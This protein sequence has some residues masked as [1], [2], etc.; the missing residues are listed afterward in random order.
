MKPEILYSV[1]A[2][3]GPTLRC[4]GWKQESLL[5]MLENNMENAEAPERLVIYGGIGKCARNWESYHAIVQ[6]LKELENDETLVIQSGMPVAIFKTHRLA[7]RV[8]MANTNI[9]K[10]TWEIFY[11]LQDK[12]LTMFAQ[13]TAGPWEYIGTQGVIQGTF[14]TLGAIAEQH[15]GGSLAG[16]IYL[17]AGLGGMGRNQPR[18]TTMH[19][20]VCLVVDA[21]QTIIQR[22]LERGFLDVQAS[23]LEEAIQ[24]AE[25]AKAARQPLGVGL[26]GNAAEIFPAALELGWLPDIM[27]EMCPC[28]DPL[29]YIPAGYSPEAAAELRATDRSLYLEVARASMKRQLAAMN[30]FFHRGVQ[31]FE[32]GTSIRKECRDAGMAED[33]AMTIPGF[34]AAYIRPLFML[35]R[36]PFRW[37]CLSGEASDLEKIDDLVLVMFPHDL[38]TVKW[39]Q[40]ARKT[41]PIEGL[42]A[43]VCYLGFG[44][45]R[46]LALRINQMIRAGELAGPVGF[47]RDNLDSGSIVNPTFESEKMKDGGDLIS[48]WP[49]LNALLNT[50]GMADLVAIQA[51]Y[52]MGEAVHTG[53]TMI[54]DGSEEADLRLDA[55][56][57]TDSGIGVV[58]HAQAG[59]ELSRQVCDGKGPL[60]QD[61]I[62][63]PLWWTPEATFGPESGAVDRLKP[64]S[65]MD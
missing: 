46:A 4:K 9:M 60:T 11:D 37:T 55:C 48:D 47:S 3:R 35:G 24:M 32:Y 2:Q 31:V 53:V 27:S 36:G 34:V 43:R 7:P 56:M 13:Y 22:S 18:A 50:A 62:K 10:A 15:Y 25:Q 64:H 38:T 61:M 57:A 33:E 17:T 39:I 29:S 42:P 8:V 54:A 1:K 6:S 41:L 58:R 23:S 44:E 21:D 49:Y 12:N 40:L 45:R 14:E 28:H 65:K 20:G 5:R 59:Y 52:S 19:G 63:V 51:N 16:T 30:E 26:H